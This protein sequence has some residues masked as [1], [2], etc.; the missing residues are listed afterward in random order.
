MFLKQAIS[1]PGNNSSGQ[2]CSG[3][4]EDV[5]L[6]SFIIITHQYCHQQ[7]LN[8]ALSLGDCSNTRFHDVG[9]L[10]IL[11][12]IYFLCHV[13]HLQIESGD[14]RVITTWFNMQGK[15]ESLIKISC[16][17]YRCQ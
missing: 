2:D 1:L 4:D 15:R 12:S 16:I 17:I 6:V 9:Y 7:T 13:S 8:S 11:F 5:E 10:T 3:D 14:M